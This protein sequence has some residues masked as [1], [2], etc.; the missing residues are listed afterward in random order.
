LTPEPQAKAGAVTRS[1]LML[2]GASLAI[3][4]FVIVLVPPEAFFQGGDGP[5]Y[6]RVGWEIAQAH[7]ST[8]LTKVGP[9]YPLFLASIWLFFPGALHAGTPDAPVAYLASVRVVQMIL[10]MVLLWLMYRTAKRIGAGRRAALVTAIGVGIGPAYVLAQQYLLTELLFVVFLAG[11]VLAYLRFREGRSARDLMI[12][13][14][15]FGMASLTRPVALLLP[16]LV[17]IHMGI[18]D[19]CQAK[20]R[21]QMTFF[22]S[23]L[24]LI[25][26]WMLWLYSV[27]GSPLP[28][29]FGAN[30]WIGASYEGRWAGTTE[31]YERSQAFGGNR[32][33]FTPEA[34]RIIGSDPLAWMGLR[35]R[36]LTGAI[37]VPYGIADLGG[38][39]LKQMASTWLSKDR[40]LSG[41]LDLVSVSTFTPKLIFYLFHYFALIFGIVGATLMMRDERRGGIV[42]AV[43]LYFLIVHTFLTALPRYLFPA[44]T[45]I[46][47]F[48]GVGF[49]RAVNWAD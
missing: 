29:G 33:D 39:S 25:V 10:G 24:V 44:L 28:E 9:V 7:L 49:V 36:N 38:P 11:A 42:L 45:L 22:A 3:R 41:V 4:L 27:S 43:I 5:Y 15:S 21:L 14:L 1:I 2:V 32:Q 16:L 37:A 47:V 31:T 13:G 8:P 18:R 40:S 35:L 30:L 46:W 34:L 26:P 6:S 19:G 48:A 12:A 20:A 23:F 17:A